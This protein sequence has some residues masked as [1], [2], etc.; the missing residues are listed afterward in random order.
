MKFTHII[1]IVFIFVLMLAGLYMFMNTSPAQPVEDNQTET[2][3]ASNP[4]NATYT[5]EGKEVTL[6]DGYA[7]QEAAPGSASKVKTRYFGNE[8]QT[9]LNDDGR[10]DVVFLLTQE[11]GGS[12]TFYYVVAA[13]NTEDGWMGSHGILLGDRIAPQTTELSQDPSHEHVIVVNYAD[14]NAGEALT[15][16]PSLGESMWL[17]LDLESM[18]FGEVMQ[19]FEGEADPSLMS[20]DMQTWTWV[21]TTYNNDTELVPNDPEAFTL[22]FN[23]DGTF[24][25][26]TDCN[27]MSGNY[28]ADESQI[29]F[30]EN[31]AMTKMYC[32]GSQEMEFAT[33][34][35]EIQ[36]YFFT[37]RG[38]LVFDL[39]LDTGSAVFR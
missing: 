18:Q 26:S 12:G 20:L 13:L 3:V 30:G 38:E 6:V 16:E 7:E 25:A 14:H 1:A 28:E 37:S 21:K 34:L 32:E 31:I 23:E 24:S 36:S 29:T 15:I 19:D 22:T 5:I 17:K 9:D 8:V 39:M 35:G 27:S 2:V 10:E 4:K 11:T 33:M